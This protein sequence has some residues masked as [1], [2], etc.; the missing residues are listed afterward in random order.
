MQKI[1]LGDA[2]PLGLMGFGLTG[3]LLG[4]HNAVFFQ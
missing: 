2:S 4:V 1:T 3:I